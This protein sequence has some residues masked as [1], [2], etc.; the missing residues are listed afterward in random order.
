MRHRRLWLQAQFDSIKTAGKKLNFEFLK[1]SG[2]KLSYSTAIYIFPD[3]KITKTYLKDGDMIRYVYVDNNNIKHDLG[4]FKLIEAQ[5]WLIAT[6]HKYK[7][8]Q[9]GEWKKVVSGGKTRYYK[10][11]GNKKTLIITPFSGSP[12][13]VFKYNDESSIDF[14]IYEDTSREYFNAYAFAT[15]IGALIE[16]NFTDVV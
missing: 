2:F 10:K 5:K 9:G 7:T 6:R 15:V 3:G 8:E 13:K 12:H 11:D 4:N 14:A 1:G 16:V